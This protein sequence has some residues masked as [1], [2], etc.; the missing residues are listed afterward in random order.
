MLAVRDIVSVPDLRVHPDVYNALL[1]RVVRQPFAVP[2]CAHPAPVCRWEVITTLVAGCLGCGVLHV[3]G[4]VLPAIADGVN[5]VE[6]LRAFACR[7]HDTCVFVDTDNE[8]VCCISA[9]G[10]AVVGSEVEFCDTLILTERPRV[11][12]AAHAKGTGRAASRKYCYSHLHAATEGCGLDSVY[13][14]RDPSKRRRVTSHL[15]PTYLAIMSQ[16]RGDGFYAECIDVLQQVLEF[17][18]ESR[19]GFYDKVLHLCVFASVVR[20][21]LRRSTR[22]ACMLPLLVCD[23]YGDVQASKRL[24]VVADRVCALM[25]KDSIRV[26]NSSVMQHEV[27]ALMRRI[28]AIY[29]RLV[30]VMLSAATARRMPTRSRLRDICIGVLYVLRKGVHDRDVTIV[31]AVDT[32]RVFLPPPCTV[33]AFFNVRAKVITDSENA[34]KALHRVININS[35]DI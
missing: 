3:C 11:R 24:R 19:G 15:R 23:T 18:W 4:N 17:C 22:R 9:V 28:S 29:V 20:S 12:L 27:A 35:L 10:V 32:L 33:R 31:P 25:T 1:W 16:T 7:V 2:V 14:E 21:E 6:R 8:K 5:V 13:Y 26:N 30:C 34:M